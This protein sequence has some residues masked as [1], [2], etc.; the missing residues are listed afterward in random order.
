MQPRRSWR[1][2]GLLA[3]AGVAGGLLSFVQVA[4]AAEFARESTRAVDIVPFSI[5]DL[6]RFLARPAEVRQ[7]VQWYDVFIGRPPAGADHFHAMYKFPLEAYR[8]VEWVWPGISGPTTA[9]WAVQS[10]FARA[11]WW[12]AS[13]YLGMFPV[14]AAIVAG[15]TQP[16]ARQTRLWTALALLAILASC[17]QIGFGSIVRWLRELLAGEGVGFAYRPGDEVGGLYWMMASVLPGYAGFRYPAKWMT[18]VSLAI[19]QL[20][21]QATDGLARDTLRQR[22]CRVALGIAAAELAVVA[23]LAVAAVRIGP[24]HVLPWSA[25]AAGRDAAFWRV[26]TGGVHGVTVAVV[27]AAVVSRWMPKKWMASAI[28]FL[29]VADLAVAGRA[30]LLVVPWSSVVEASSYLQGMHAGRRPEMAC[31]GRR[32][33]IRKSA[34]LSSSSPAVADVLPDADLVR[35]GVRQIGLS[36]SGHLPW[37]HGCEVIGDPSTSMYL[38]MDALR[39]SRH[40][41]DETIVPR[42]FLDSAGVEFLFVMNLREDEDNA[43]SVFNDWSA[44]QLAG[45][46]EGDVPQGDPMPA[47]GIPVD[48]PP[49]AAPLAR[50]CRNESVLPRARIVR[51]V[52][53]VPPV[54]QAQRKRWLGLLERVAFPTPDVP[55]LRRAA[56]VEMPSDR[57]P[58]FP[59]SRPGAAVPVADACRVVVD[60]PQRVVVEADLAEPGLLY[61]ADT[62]HRDWTAAVATAGS[63]PQLA[64][65]LRANR[66]HRG[67]GLPAGRHR[68]EFRYASRTF[69]W[70]APITAAAWCVAACVAVWSLRSRGLGRR[71]GGAA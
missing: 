52:A 14:L 71:E 41:G 30:D 57:G 1:G 66:V 37:M 32:V 27:I 59:P 38:D 6:P 8:L 68:V 49:E 5:W 10:E 16:L 70:T 65:V 9:R 50:V 4:L 54:E 2:L 67:V 48:G 40:R 62:F 7:G 39:V 61:L 56:I 31:C 60:E 63:Q 53:T 26:L 34:K 15:G 11:D 29:V 45:E 20:A 36:A 3:A 19:G 13:I 55:D 69:N 12:T 24:G 17:G 64:P 35:D 44:R 46:F 28:A 47:L 21:A 18:I 23:L 42:R 33:R 22:L 25:A 51:D 43:P 58:L